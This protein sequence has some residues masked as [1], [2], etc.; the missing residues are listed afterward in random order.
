GDPELIVN[1]EINVALN[2][3]AA[4]EVGRAADEFER[5][6]EVAQRQRDPWM[7][8]RYRLHIADGHGRV[9]LAANQPDLALA[10]AERQLEGARRHRVPKVEA[11]A[12]ELRGRSLLASDD[13]EGAEASLRQAVETA[14]RIAY[15]RGVWRALAALAELEQRRCANGRAAALR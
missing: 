6:H 2:Q 8:W 11:R 1:S 7:R 4:G 3:L 5:L 15:P 9:A 13:R 12:L 14:Q 10:Q